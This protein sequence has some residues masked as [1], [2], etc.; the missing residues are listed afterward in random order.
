[1]IDRLAS[2]GGGAIFGPRVVG[3]TSVSCITLDEFADRHDVRQIDYLK[4]DTQGTELD[5]IRG[6][7]RIVRSK[8]VI[9]TEV[10]FVEMYEGQD[11]FDEVARELSL[12]GFRFLDFTDG[13]RHQGK[14]IWADALFV[15]PQLDRGRAVKAAAVLIELHRP[16]DARWLLLDT[17]WDRHDIAVLLEAG[18]YGQKPRSIPRT[19]RNLFRFITG[20]LAN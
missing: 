1:L 6:G 20:R 2:E 13:P 15:R 3:K 19:P 9:R 5:I 14:R 18:G 4:L 16:T 11:L 12:A 17:G 7:E 10:E 8:L